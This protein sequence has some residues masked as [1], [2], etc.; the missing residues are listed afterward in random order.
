ME[1]EIVSLAREEGADQSFET[2]RSFLEDHFPEEWWADQ[3]ETLWAQCESEEVSATW[4]TT[5]GCPLCERHK[6]LTRHHVYPREIHNSL[7]KKG[8]SN[9]QLNTTIAICRKCHSALHRFF[10]HRELAERLYS[11]ELLL[12][13]E[14]FARYARWASTQK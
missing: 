9:D 12:A 10:P 1:E 13:D 8:Y 11:V 5:D 2:F 7:R 4:Q 3:V 6:P 14:T